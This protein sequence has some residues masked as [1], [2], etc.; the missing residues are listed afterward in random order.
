MSLGT[1][2]A[3]GQH[4]RSW[5]LSTVEHGVALRSPRLRDGS[6]NIGVVSAQP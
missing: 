5:R 6:G 4:E 2:D 3:F 1:K